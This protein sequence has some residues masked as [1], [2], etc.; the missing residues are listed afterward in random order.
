ME[1]SYSVK[2]GMAAAGIGGIIAGA[3]MIIP[4]MGMMSMM[5]LPADLFSTIV[6]I[7][8]GKPQESAAMT[9]MTLHFV[10][11]ILIGLIFG[12]IISSSKLAITGF[13]KGISLGIA[14]GIVSFVVLFIPM[15]MTVMPPAMLQLMQMM[16]PGASQETIMSQLQ[17]M[18]PMLLGGSLAA[19]I[20][21]G[22]VLGT[23]TTAILRKRIQ[24]IQI[25]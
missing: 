23:I 6:G 16:N 12:V 17:S 9:G 21:Y 5:N 19:H 15:M 14:A 22:A 25:R 8:V 3:V 18:Q 10:P 24:K 13:K 11:S 7:T 2:N 20:V 4:M 1:K